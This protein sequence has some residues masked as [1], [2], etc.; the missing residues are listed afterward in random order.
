MKTS[1][2]LIEIDKDNKFV[3]RAQLKVPCWSYGSE[4]GGKPVLD[5]EAHV[6]VEAI[7]RSLDLATALEEGF[8][9]AYKKTKDTFNHKRRP[10]G[11]LRC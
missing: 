5:M 11:S 3:I 2:E 6:L 9:K 1:W 8:R 10:N 7:A 4:E